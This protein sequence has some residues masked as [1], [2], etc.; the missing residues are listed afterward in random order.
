MGGGHT[1]LTTTLYPG[2]FGYIGLFSAATFMDLETMHS[3]AEYQA[4]MKALF[5]ADPVLYYIGMGKTDF[6]Y[7]SCVDLRA[8]LDEN[9]Y[10]YQYEETEGGHIW[11][12]WRV[13]LTHFAEQLFK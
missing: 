9:N 6:L 4:Q 7:Q 13:Y 2:T 1:V 3:D 12:N 11:R 8:F 5:D 10:P